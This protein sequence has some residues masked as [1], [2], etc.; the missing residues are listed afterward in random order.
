MM[1]VTGGA[2]G[3]VPPPVREDTVT[4][5]QALL[6]LDASILALPGMTSEWVE[7]F[8]D[9][10][11]HVASNRYALETTV[12]LP[13]RVSRTVRVRALAVHGDA[14]GTSSAT[15]LSRVAALTLDAGPRRPRR[16]A[17]VWWLTTDPGPERPLLERA[18]SLP[19]RI[20]PGR[21]GIEPPLVE[22]VEEVLIGWQ[23]PERVAVEPPVDAVYVREHA[24]PA[25]LHEFVAFSHDAS[26]HGVVLIVQTPASDEVRT[27]LRDA[28]I[29]MGFPLHAPRNIRRL[30]WVSR[31]AGREVAQDE[32]LVPFV[33]EVLPV[34]PPR[35]AA[36]W[37]ALLGRLTRA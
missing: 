4:E 24:L 6:Y 1:C 29:R 15:A 14:L 7:Q 9:L 17:Q 36:G 26:L 28:G 27:V 25:D 31:V 18:G 11:D 8:N 30:M 32:R 3:H 13:P 2:T 34:R 35:D 20:L 16:V 22:D 10:V 37:S 5:P 21:D 12:L 23:P 19:L 33:D